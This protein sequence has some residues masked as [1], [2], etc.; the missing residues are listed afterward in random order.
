M[1]RIFCVIIYSIVIL[2]K[3]VL[4][5]KFNGDDCS[6]YLFFII[7]LQYKNVKL[8]RNLHNLI[9]YENIILLFPPKN[10]LTFS[11]FLI[12]MVIRV[13]LDLHANFFSPTLHPL[14]R[15]DFDHI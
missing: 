9:F 5:E 8:R 2:Q 10:F 11:F 13:S 15:F 14:P 6:F 7:F 1:Q 3:Y 4:K 12:I